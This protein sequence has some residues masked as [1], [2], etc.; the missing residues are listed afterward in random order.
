M[1]AAA[2][3]APPADP[4]S[5][6]S[7]GVLLE[8]ASSLDD[9][10]SLFASPSRAESLYADAASSLGG[11]LARAS[12]DGGEL[13]AD[14][15]GGGPAAWR[16]L[17]DLRRQLDEVAAALRAARGAAD[18]APAEAAA[19]VAAE[20][21]ALRAEAEGRAAAA[22]L[23]ATACARA[24][25][26]AEWAAERAELEAR[27]EAAARVG[28]AM[29]LGRESRRR[30]AGGAGAWRERALSSALAVGCS[31]AGAAAAVLLIRSVTS[32]HH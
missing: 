25:A 7:A 22:R 24:A 9:A 29:C 26:A 17:L 13:L 32:H 4:L 30:E 11:P 3:Q 5:P 14:A 19:A 15:S 18:E 8:P 16:A 20:C 10:A 2:R 21:L 28:E 1:A 31:A 6:A 23:A 12:V 27:A